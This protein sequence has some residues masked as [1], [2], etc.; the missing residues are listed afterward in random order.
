MDSACRIAMGIGEAS[1]IKIA[2]LLLDDMPRSHESVW[3]CIYLT[4]RSPL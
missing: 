4:V 2:T 3:L 1:N